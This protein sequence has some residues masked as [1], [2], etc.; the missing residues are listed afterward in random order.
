MI[1]SRKWTRHPSRS[2]TARDDSRDSPFLPQHPLEPDRGRWH[3][4]DDNTFES[5]PFA[6][7]DA[8]RREVQA[9]PDDADDP[10]TTWMKWLAGDPAERAV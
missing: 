9:L 2:E 8:A 5:V 10:Q 1:A 3:V 4:N 7:F 6:A